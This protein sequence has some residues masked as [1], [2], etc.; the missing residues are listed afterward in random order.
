MLF[1]FAGVSASWP[2]LTG[3]TLGR[4][5]GVASVWRGMTDALGRD[6]SAMGDTVKKNKGKEHAECALPLVHVS[7]TNVYPSTKQKKLDNYFRIILI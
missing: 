2:G 3:G 4:A 7:S 1:E 5:R 6:I